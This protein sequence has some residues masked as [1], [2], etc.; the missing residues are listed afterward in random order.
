MAG[1]RTNLVAGQRPVGGMFDVLTACWIRFTLFAVCFSF[2]VLP[3]FLPLA[4]RG[5]LLAMT[6]PSLVASRVAISADVSV[7]SASARRDV[8]CPVQDVVTPAGWSPSVAWPL[9]VFWTA[10]G[11]PVSPASLRPTSMR[12]GLAGSTTGSVKVSTPSW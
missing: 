12:R 7:V 1:M 10:P 4:F 11:S 5:D 3:C 6:T 9:M 2:N 8:C